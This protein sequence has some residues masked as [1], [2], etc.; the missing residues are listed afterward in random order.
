LT[1]WW[2]Q[3]CLSRVKSE[4]TRWKVIPYMLATVG[5]GQDRAQRH[6]NE[7]T[8]CLAK[9]SSSFAKSCR[10]PAKNAPYGS[11]SGAISLGAVSE[12]SRKGVLEM[13]EECGNI[14]PELMV[15][16]VLDVNSW[17]SSRLARDKKDKKSSTS[18][19]PTRKKKRNKTPREKRK[20]KRNK[21]PREKQQEEAATIKV[22]RQAHIGDNTKQHLFLSKYLDILLIK[23]DCRK[24]PVTWIVSAYI[25][26]W[27][28]HAG[29]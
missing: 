25:S 14:V 24:R 8:V 6:G 7:I 29:P 12:R 5:G 23:D 15:P 11:W 20:K 13:V 17:L 9:H 21:T 28:E 4:N 22:A 27:I 1:L 26:R 19:G 2:L 18:A 16:S 3:D 10:K